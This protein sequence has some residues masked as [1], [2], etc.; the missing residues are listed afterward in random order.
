MDKFIR[1]CAE[2]VF[3]GKNLGEEEANRL[4]QASGADFLQLLASA[5]KIKE[6]LAEN[7][8]DLC[9][10]ISAKTGKCSEDCAFCAQSAHHNTGVQEHELL[11]EEVI[12][13]KAKQM[14]KLGAHRFDIVI[15]GKGI[16]HGTTDFNRILSIMK[17][18]KQETE[19]ELCG[20]L[21]TLTEEGV[22]ALK[23]VGVT[24]YNHN[25]ETARSFFSKIVSTHTYEER[26]ETVR[27]VKKEGMEICCGGII[28]MGESMAQRIEF[29]I[30]LRELDVDAVP[31]NILLPV[32]GTRLAEQPG[33]SPWEVLKTIAIFR[34][35]LPTKNIRYAGGREKAL[36]ELQP[37]GILAGL[38]GM[39]IGGYLTL[40]GVEVEKDLEMLNTPQL[41]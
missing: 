19:L 31:L 34:F 38:N 9:S 30:T 1:E 4:A 18:I 3:A 10:I 23:E 5:G 21:G 27:A 16:K 20:C 28:G 14:A 29:A 37:L 24:R 39:L 15:S 22:K 26:L 6:G 40:P 7:K 25:L 35:L 2:K 33:L 36:G 11:D 13:A 32:A 8:V 12:L 41:L 17:R